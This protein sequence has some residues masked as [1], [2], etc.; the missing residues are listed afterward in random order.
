MTMSI[1]SNGEIF[2]AEMVVGA[3][4]CVAMVVAFV[5]RPVKPRRRRG[6]D[7][8]LRSA[9]C[10][11]SEGEGEVR[12]FERGLIDREV[13]RIESMGRGWRGTTKPITADDGRGAA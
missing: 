6:G 9:E 8:G 7:C 5:L 11:L 10:G 12:F 13:L 1:Y 2:L 3:L 4:L